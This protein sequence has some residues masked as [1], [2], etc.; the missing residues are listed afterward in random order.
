MNHNDINKKLCLRLEIAA[1]ITNF[2][3]FNTSRLYI[4]E[5]FYTVPVCYFHLLSMKFNMHFQKVSDWQEILD[6]YYLE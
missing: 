2:S 3:Y 5:S 4:L 1:C 6:W